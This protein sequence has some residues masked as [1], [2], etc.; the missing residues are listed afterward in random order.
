MPLHIFPVFNSLNSKWNCMIF[1]LMMFNVWAIY[2]F[3]SLNAI[4]C[5]NFIYYKRK[6]NVLFCKHDLALY[7]FLPLYIAKWQL[8]N[9]L[10]VLPEFH[11]GNDHAPCDL[12]RVYF[13][14]NES[15]S[16]QP[17]IYNLFQNVL[18]INIH[19]NSYTFFHIFF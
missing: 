13:T 19:S 11:T 17:T 12:F 5:Q 6:F 4:F 1:K 8:F 9:H 10:T 3:L 16:Q 2:S 15:T 18:W 14:T 7:F